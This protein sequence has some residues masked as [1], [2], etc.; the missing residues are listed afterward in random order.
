MYQHDRKFLWQPTAVQCKSDKVNTSQRLY[1]E[2]SALWECA[3]TLIYWV[4]GKDENHRRFWWQTVKLFLHVRCTSACGHENCCT[5]LLWCSIDVSITAHIRTPVS[6]A[7]ETSLLYRYASVVKTGCKLFF[8]Y[9]AHTHFPLSLTSHL[10]FHYSKYQK[11]TGVKSQLLCSWR[12]VAG[13]LF[14]RTDCTVNV[15]MNFIYIKK[16]KPVRVFEIAN[17][18]R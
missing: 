10:Y 1:S 7:S 11:R 15:L 9:D 12:S 4:R 3:E 14:H 6:Y 8:M 5:F 13:F 2:P 16:R 18:Q 17:T